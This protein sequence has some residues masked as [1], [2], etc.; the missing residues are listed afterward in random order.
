MS[1]QL[2]GQL[3]ISKVMSS[4]ED[5]FMRIEI[6]DEASGLEVVQVKLSLEDFAKAITSSVVYVDLRYNDSSNVGKVREL[7]TVRVSKGAAKYDSTPEELRA[8]VA[9]Y[10]VDGWRCSMPKDLL[11]GHKSVVDE[12]TKERLQALTF[13]RYVD[14]VEE[15]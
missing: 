14:K 10:E 1:K 9:P 2:K 4:H 15:V 7:K 3:S 12:V 11:N 8:I 13:T 5:P 6:D